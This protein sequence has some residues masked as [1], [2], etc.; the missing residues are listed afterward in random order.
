MATKAPL[1]EVSAKIG[2]FGA[3]RT[4][5]VEGTGAITKSHGH[6]VLRA[7]IT[8]SEARN[9]AKL[10][11]LAKRVPVEQEARTRA[12]ASAFSSH[13]LSSKM[14]PFSDR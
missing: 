10:A 7:G 13:G 6:L 14:L 11:E 9:A 2:H 3:A 4:I 1:L 12:K 5:K 8:E